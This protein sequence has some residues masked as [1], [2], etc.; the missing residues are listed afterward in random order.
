MAAIAGDANKEFILIDSV[1]YT[2][3]K[4]FQMNSVLLLF[5]SV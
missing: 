4:T 2:F 1:N 5:T 3:E